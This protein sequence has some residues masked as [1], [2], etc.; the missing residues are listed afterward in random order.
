MTNDHTTTTGEA[1]RRSLGDALEV[2]PVVLGGNVF[3]WTADRDTSFEVLDRFVAGG[4]NA[5]DTADVYSAWV[6]GNSGGESETIIGEWLAARTRPSDLVVATKVAMW[7][8][9]P[10]LSPDN[11]ARAV[12]GS[13]GRLGVDAI[14]L[15]YAHQEDPGTPIAESAAAMSA[16][17]D[18]GKVRYLGLSNY[19]PAAM[20]EWIEVADREGLHR[21]VALQPRYSLVERGIEDEVLPTA[22]ELGLGVLP[23][24]TLASGFLT[25]KYRSDAPRPDTPRAAGAGAYLESAHGERILRA[26]DGISGRLKVQPGS[27]A[28]AWLLAKPGIT[29]PI[30]SARNI[31][32]LPLLLD[33][34]RI[35]LD[36]SEID[37]LDRA[38]QG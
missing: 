3:G 34:A 38:S 33:A 37:E 12:D 1:P 14:D 25:G 23:Y 28:L 5:I 7:S 31:A 19:S 16:L 29:A 11:I 36:P 6:P 20:R 35:T 24:S 21:P 17:V 4:G 32:Q 10:G 2:F 15:Y 18:A 26:L 8:E 22:R 30:A 13:L 27:V 9:A